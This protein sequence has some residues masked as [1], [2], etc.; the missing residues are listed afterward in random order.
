MNNHSTQ[1][2]YICETRFQ[3]ARR[4]DSIPDT[5]PEHQLHGHGFHLRAISA[6]PCSL[7]PIQQA[8]DYSLLNDKLDQPDDLALIKWLSEDSQQ[9]LQLTS[10][11]EKGT[12]CRGDDTLVWSHFR[13]EA[14]HRLP[15][16]EPGHQC[17]RMHG[18]GFE[19]RIYTRPT[20]A[21]AVE[22]RSDI[23]DAWSP[24]FKQLDHCCLNH[25]KGLENP[26]SEMLAGWLWP[27]LLTQLPQL[28]RV[29]VQETHTAGCSYNGKDYRIWKDQRFESALE[30]PQLPDGDP[31][32]N[33]HGHSYMLR[34]E[35][36]A[37]LDDVYGWTVDFGDVKTLFKPIY[38]QLDHHQ[39][40]ELEGVESGELKPLLNWIY[41]Q[42][43][44]KLKKLTA[45]ELMESPDKGARLEW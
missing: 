42:S 22:T 43:A 1:F 32:K 6:V 5:Y 9:A 37:A 3:A 26:T 31:R 23:E 24:L 4:L 11:P 20:Q 44:P 39:L 30:L 40:N 16:V 45:I 8:L 41:Q 27:R 18:H 19:V 17:G 29:T 34:L 28:V 7:Q 21:T 25:I 35:L 36:T 10:A 38:K 14:A 15:N 12:E 33:L 13:F 2:F